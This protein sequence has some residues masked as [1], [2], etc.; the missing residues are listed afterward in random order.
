MFRYAYKNIYCGVVKGANQAF[1]IP[2]NV[3]FPEIPELANRK[4]R[5]IVFQ[6]E[7]LQSFSPDGNNLTPVDEFYYVTLLDQTGFAFIDRVPNTFFTP[8]SGPDD[9]A[10]GNNIFVFARPVVVDWANSFLTM[11]TNVD[12]TVT[13][14]II[15]YL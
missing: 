10:R 1:D 9:A 3:N 4:I 15:D 7:D 11:V 6:D 8:Y 14:F 5:S 12:D 2:H 13:P